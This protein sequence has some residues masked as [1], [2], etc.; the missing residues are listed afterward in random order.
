MMYI[1][2]EWDYTETYQA[3]SERYV[4]GFDTL[5]DAQRSV[6][7]LVAQIFEITHRGLE[8]V[9]TGMMTRNGYEWSPDA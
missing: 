4:G 3:P 8:L 5:L 1:L 2:F 7:K 6:S 9:A